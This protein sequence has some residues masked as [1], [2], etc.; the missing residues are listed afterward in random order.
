MFHFFA[1]HHGLCL[2]RALRGLTLLLLAALAVSA[3]AE[4]PQPALTAIHP[5]GGRQHS[6]V[7]VSL[8]GSDL[9]DL[10]TLVFSHPGITATPILSPPTE[11]D[12]EARP[13]PQRMLVSIGPDV[14]PGVYD[15][16]AVGRFGVSNARSFVVGT[17][18]EVVKER[19]VDSVATA[20]DL[21]TDGTVS[22]RA[23]AGKADHYALTLKAGQRLRAEVWS[24]RIDS[25][26]VPVL[27]VLDAAGKVLATPRRA[28]QEDPL[29][30]FIAPADGRFVVRIHDRFASGGEELFYRLAVSTGP[31]IDGVFPPVVKPAATPDERATLTLLGSALPL[32]LPAGLAADVEGL[33]QALV[34]LRLAP[35]QSGAVAR[36]HWRLHAPRDAASQLVD[37]QVD[38]PGMPQTPLPVLVSAETVVVEHNHN[39]SPL[40][41]QAVTLPGCIAGRFYPQRDRDWFGFTAK[42][43]E[44]FV[45]EVFSAR[46]GLPT[47]PALL[48][49]QVTTEADGRT[50]AKEIAYADDGPSEF[51]GGILDRPTADP[52][53]E[54]K[55]PADGSYRMLVRDLKGESHSSPEHVYVVE[56]R[57]PRPTFHL[58]ALLAQPHRADAERTLIATPVLPIGGTVGID[59]LV[60]KS[61]GFSGDVTLFAEGLPAGVSAAPTVAAARSN[62]ALLGLTAAAGSQPWA[63]TIRVV[64]RATIGGEEVV[65]T[66]RVAMLRWNADPK[67]QHPKLRELHSL[68]LAVTPDTAP[69]SITTHESRIWE[70]ARGGKLSVPLD[71]VRQPEATGGL[72]LTAANLPAELKVPEVKIE[73]ATTST[74]A[75][76]ELDPKLPAGT[77]QIVLRGLAKEKYARN[78]PAAEL[79]KADAQRIGGLAKQR[80]EQVETARLAVAAAEKLLAETQLAAQQATGAPPDS[81][82]L[83]A[84]CMAGKAAADKTLS[85]A[86]AKAKAMEEERARRE[87]VAA[88]AA[89]ASVPK[90]VEVPVMATPIMLVV[91]ESPLQLT[92]PL[93]IT[94]QPGATAEL[95]IPLERRYGLSG[96][97][98][99]EPKLVA[100]AVSLT[101]LPVTA[102][103]DQP[104][105]TIK[106]I[107]GAD[108]PPGRHEVVIGTKT[109]YFDREVSGEQKVVLVVAAPVPL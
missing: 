34:P 18:A 62:R 95:V 57:R 12:P 64:G 37:L 71:V 53:V 32:G 56:V 65:Q 33:E 75:A 45:F 6:Q 87:K 73:E 4:L 67:V 78:P 16:E 27:S 76:I 17:G 91:A 107:A 93:E 104:Q 35:P 42:A 74:V 26:M 49:E 40:E 54:F 14:P 8:L 66:A 20:L 36:T 101:L 30:D 31:Q 72:T 106:I 82:Q 29:L 102:P 7:A 90:D 9:D 86:E 23:V 109:Q 98:S 2:T 96:P 84:A 46:L 70:T 21:P 43:G 83:I 99:F 81:Q 55:A 94:I 24:R 68:P 28:R 22:G 80:V 60:L 79:A 1:T 69:L 52:L 105:A 108:A 97:V 50:T 15:V 48:I 44:R 63:G 77:Y 51:Q 5:P 47:D 38:L 10:R 13:I 103:P 61:D 85:E 92:L 59:V 3:R 39:D 25:R 58:L 11:L 88:D 41:P 89:A 19:D 100:P